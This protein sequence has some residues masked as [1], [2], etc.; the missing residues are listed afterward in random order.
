MTTKAD[1]TEEEYQTLVM[2]MAQAGMAVAVASYSGAFGTIKEVM[3]LAKSAVKGAQA[4]PENELVQDVVAALNDKDSDLQEKLKAEAQLES[5]ELDKEKGKEA[6]IAEVID[7]ALETCGEAADILDAKSTAEEA[8]GYKAWLV[9][10]AE[11]VAVSSKEGDFLGFGGTRISEAE[12]A[13]ID[14]LKVALRV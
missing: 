10:I 11:D 1:Y 14:R 2:S 8:A 5:D 4:H 12:V 9:S 7:N 6:L 3:A 13:T